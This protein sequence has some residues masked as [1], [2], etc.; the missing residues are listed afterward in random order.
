MI[1]YTQLQILGVCFFVALSLTCI[2]M[3]VF[4]QIR[5]RGY[6]DFSSLEMRTIRLKIPSEWKHRLCFHS[7]YVHTR[8]FDCNLSV[9][10]VFPSFLYHCFPSCF[11]LFA[12]L[13]E[14]NVK[15]LC[16][17]H[18]NCCRALVGMLIYPHNIHTT[19]NTV[20]SAV[21]SQVFPSWIL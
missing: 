19:H 17:C 7:I 11:L 3:L 1:I 6:W 18:L 16:V 13:Q 9:F 4:C 20:I 14:I 5:P 10:N 12:V 8:R 21:T 2:R 15:A